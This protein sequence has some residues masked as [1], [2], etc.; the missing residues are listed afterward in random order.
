MNT[1]IKEIASLV[2][3]LNFDEFQSE[4]VLDNSIEGV[5][6]ELELYLETHARNKEKID[7]IIDY[8]A[9]ISH[10]VFPEPLTISEKQDELDVICMS[11]NILAEELQQNAFSINALD[12]IFNSLYSPFFIVNP[13]KRIIIKHNNAA[14]LFFDYKG[15]NKFQIFID[16]ILHQ[17]I[18]SELENF[19]HNKELT[20]FSIQKEILLN[21]ENRQIIL[22]LNKI[23]S[24][25]TNEQLISVFITD[26]TA[27]VENE[28]HIKAKEVAEHSSKMKEEFLANM[29]HEIR[30]PMNAI[31]G[32]SNLL[33]KSQNLTD[34]Q[35]EYIK[36]I[37]INSKNL[38]GIIN[39]I[40][41]YSKIEAGKIDFE[42]R[43]F[44]IRE[45]IQYIY[46]ALCMPIKEKGVLFTTYVDS[47]IP[48]FIQGDSV[49]LNQVL[50]NLVSNAAKFTAKGEI[51]L[52]AQLIDLSTSNLRIR[53]S[54]KDT[55][56]GIPIEKQKSIFDSF[57]Q[58]TNET[59]RKY[60]GTGLGL[61]IVKKIIELQ[62]GTIDIKSELNKGSEFYFDLAFDL[63]QELEII[64]TTKKSNNSR[65]NNLS[66][67]LV[68]DNAFN[69]LVA[70]DTL[71]DAS[72]KIEIDVADNGLIAI[73]KLKVKTYD[74][75]LMDIQMPE[76]DGH[77]A[78]KTIREVLQISTPIIAMTAHA[79]SKE[80][81]TCFENGMNEYV[82]KPFDINNLLEKIEKVTHKKIPLESPVDTS[83]IINFTKGNQERINKMVKMF[84]KDTP[85]EISLLRTHFENKQ[86]NSLKTLAHSIKPKFEI[87]GMPD[88]K[89][90]SAQIEELSVDELNL[91]KIENC[92][93]QLE[94]KVPQSYEI[95]K[96]LIK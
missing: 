69:Q 59:T 37:N 76:M 41:D 27:Q 15:E 94:I 22:N 39:D 25:Y 9:N 32:L 4:K 95:F 19:Y 90:I 80:I 11:L 67:L 43:A 93:S 14:L 44:D 51:I 20:S 8:A 56:I 68:E 45:S 12:E 91:T 3:G 38:L 66:I 81:E 88:F 29:S 28:K 47:N 21:K 6:K 26:I 87:M 75:I 50:T 58:A 82:T 2:N 46:E 23:T 30:T 78:T 65:L 62:K 57:T 85:N 79:S 17:T 74:L 52:S 84:L 64:P 40:L 61:A 71:K 73:Q 70:V 1:T 96:K 54:V 49:K 77:T 92:I 5:L 63:P 31:V 48:D 35:N 34:K 24:T 42:N 89:T 72:E 18:V 53:F 83:I 10:G 7:L 55:G 16:N 33:T 60:G 13:L 36:S 86:M